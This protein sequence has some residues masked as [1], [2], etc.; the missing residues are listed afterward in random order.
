MEISLEPSDT[1][2]DTRLVYVVNDSGFYRLNSDVKSRIK[3]PDLPLLDSSYRVSNVIVSV[4]S[5]VIIFRLSSVSSCCRYV[6]F[7]IQ[8]SLLSDGK[9]HCNLI[10]NDRYSE[11]S[12][13]LGEVILSRCILKTQSPFTF[14]FDNLLGEEVCLEHSKSIIETY[15]AENLFTNK[16]CGVI[17]DSIINNTRFL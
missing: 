16:L 9:L 12:D 3:I 13:Y 1:L 17:Y 15:L 2:L 5:P 4:E 7:Y 10:A 8:M 14:V 6:E 11:V